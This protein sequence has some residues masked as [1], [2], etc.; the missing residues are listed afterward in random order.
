MARRRRFNGM[1]S[2]NALPLVDDSAKVMDVAVGAAVGL[3][4][5]GAVK[6]ALQK[7]MPAQYEQLRSTAGKFVPALTGFAAAA[8]L[9]YLQQGSNKSRAIGHAAGAAVAG[10][11]LTTQKILEETKPLGL[12]FAETT[13][14]N[15]NELYS[16]RGMGSFI[17]GDKSDGITPGMAGFIVGDRTDGTNNSLAELAAYSM[18]DDQDGV[19]MLAG[20]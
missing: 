4:V 20:A 11:A 7:I 18:G 19:D 2:L 9:Y 13:A 12:N 8:G 6:V 3:V 15:L 10:I 16:R 1:V 5:S 17:V 14:I